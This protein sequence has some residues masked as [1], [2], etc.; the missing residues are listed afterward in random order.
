M[1]FSQLSLLP[2]LPD[3]LVGSITSSISNGRLDVPKKAPA[4][5]QRDG[6]IIENAIYSRW[7]LAKEYHIWMFE[8]IPE[9]YKAANPSLGFQSIVPPREGITS[10]VHPHTD[11]LSKGT[12]SIMYLISPGGDNVETVF[13]KE[14]GKE[15]KRDPWSH[16]WD[17]NKL[18]EAGKA[19]FK[20]GTWN[21][22]RTDILHSVQNVTSSRIALTVAFTEEELFF[23]IMEKYK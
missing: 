1:I 12:F 16:C 6:L 19:V 9:L 2:D 18:T 17:M 23:K 11:A 5:I 15:L 3:Y 13:W 4:I 21:I 20:K 7:A 22:F 10:L 14:N 8:N